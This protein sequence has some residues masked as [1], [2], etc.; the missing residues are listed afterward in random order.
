[1][2][3]TVIAG[4]VGALAVLALLAPLA[5]AGERSVETGVLQELNFARTQPQAYARVLRDEAYR[6]QAAGAQTDPAAIEEAIAF[7]GRQRPLGP[8]SPD[9]ALAGAA[10]EHVSYQ[11]ADGGVGHGGP[12]GESF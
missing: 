1:M 12:G 5:L 8:L 10:L 4:A 6:A 3:R 2:A 9:S 7:L 11:A